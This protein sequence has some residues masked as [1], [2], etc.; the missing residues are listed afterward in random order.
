MFLTVRK[1][2]FSTS[3]AVHFIVVKTY[4]VAT[5]LYVV[6]I[7]MTSVKE[8]SIAKQ[9]G[10]TVFSCLVFQIQLGIFRF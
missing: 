4:Q 6:K 9:E 7:S 2:T 3:A 8:T 1:F 5:I 10:V